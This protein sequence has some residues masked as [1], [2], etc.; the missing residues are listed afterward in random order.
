MNEQ[1]IQIFEFPNGLTLLVEEM[2]HVQSASFSIMTPAGV[3]YE[4]ESQNG[5]AAA[6]C[7]LMTRGAGNLNSRQM[8]NALDNL[9]VQRN[10]NVGWNFLSFA[11]ATLADNLVKALPLYADILQRPVLPE[12]QFEAV[13]SGIEQSLLAEE[14][15]PQRK[16]LTELRKYCYDAPWNRPTDGS[17]SELENISL[18]GAQQFYD[19]AVRPNGTLIGVAGNVSAAQVRDVVAECFG[20]WGTVTPPELSRQPVLQQNHHLPHDS[21]QTHIGLAYHAVPYGHADYYAAWAAVSILSGGS[22][23]RLFTEVREK[24]GLC[25]SVYATL[26]SLLTE[27]RVLAYAGTATDRAQETLDVMVAEMRKL[28][29]GVTEAELDRCKARAKSSLIMQQEST[30]ARASAIARDWFHLR[31]VNTLTD[32]HNALNDLTVEQIVDYACRYP[33]RDFTVLTI[34]EKELQLPE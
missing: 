1:S 8:S 12:D 5:T 29:D 23:S 30:G 33:A 9:G 10:E 7:D 32:I 18:T 34:G 3:V 26:N 28:A 27:G 20:S 2:P 13:M 16:V 19:R 31:R 24:R 4:P 17:L 6:L 21:T 14:D 25:Y 22:S 15:E 11:G